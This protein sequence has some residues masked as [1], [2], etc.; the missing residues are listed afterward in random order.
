MIAIETDWVFSMSSNLKWKQKKTAQDSS[1]QI[2]PK[3]F[4]FSLK[5]YTKLHKV[6]ITFLV[7]KII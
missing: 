6:D 2:I 7:L 3:F 1:G 5:E 4:L